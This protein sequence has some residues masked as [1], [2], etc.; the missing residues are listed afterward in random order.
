MNQSKKSHA[1]TDEPS[2]E[3]FC[4][5]AWQNDLELAAHIC[6]FTE[7]VL[8]VAGE[9]GSG[10]TAFLH[11]LAS[12]LQKATKF[13][14]LTASRAWDVPTCMRRLAQGLGLDWQESHTEQSNTNWI[15]AIDDA[16]SMTPEVILALKKLSVNNK[17]KFIFTITLSDTS[18]VYPQFA[19]TAR[20][21]ITIKPLPVGEYLKFN[22]QLTNNKEPLPYSSKQITKI[23]KLTKGIPRAIRLHLDKDAQPKASV[24]KSWLAVI[25]C[26]IVIVCCVRLLVIKKNSQQVVVSVPT[27]INTPST[28]APQTPSYSRDKKLLE[29]K[30]LNLKLSTKPKTPIEPKPVPKVAKEVPKTPEVTVATKPAK[31]VT[32]KLVQPVIATKDYPLDE[33]AIFQIPANNYTYQLIGLREDKRIA[34]FLKSLPTNLKPMRYKAMFQGM[35]WT[36]IILGNFTSSTDADKFLQQAPEIKQLGPWLRQYKN[37]QADIRKMY[38][39]SNNSN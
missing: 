33:L 32:P 27:V 23:A 6:L 31:T 14:L 8:F 24:P 39:R 20:Y 13:V 16:D 10:K 37:V 25:F 11:L 36:V 26:L 22:W 5:P 35:P 34:P 29:L 19:D 4:S 17:L 28:K 1:I 3:L 2:R 7:Q 12:K 38:D 9:S 15:V 30:Q 21:V 18:R